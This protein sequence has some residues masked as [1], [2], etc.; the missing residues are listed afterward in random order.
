MPWF[1]VAGTGD[2]GGQDVLGIKKNDT[3][4]ALYR[5]DAEYFATQ[6]IC[7]HQFAFLSEGYVVDGCIECPLHQA[8]FNIKTGKG[9]GGLAKTDLKTYPVKVEGDRIFVLID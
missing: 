3:D 4:I 8:M 6:N 1:D 2:F 5:L 7:T 9:C